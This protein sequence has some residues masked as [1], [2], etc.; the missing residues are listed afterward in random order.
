MARYAPGRRYD[1]QGIRT[2]FP[3][4]RRPDTRE[5]AATLARTVNET[6]DSLTPA[7]LFEAAFHSASIGMALVGLDG[8]WLRVN[9]AV[10]R[11]LG[12][13]EAELQKR[14]LQDITHPDDL[15]PGTPLCKQLLSGSIPQFESERRCLHKDDRIVWLL[16]SVALARDHRGQPAVFVVQMQDITARKQAETAR[17]MMLRLPVALHYVAG[18]DGYFKELS[19]SWADFLGYPI[20]HLLATPF[21]RLVH[22]DDRERT[23]EEIGRV[24]E[25]KN[26]FL[27]E[28]RYLH[29]DGST[30]WLLWT[31]IT[32]PE[33]KLIYGIALDYTAR[34]EAELALHDSLQEKE[35]LLTELRDAQ[36]ESQS[37]RDRLLT[38]CA[39]TKQIQHEGRWVP[40][41]EFLTDH[42]HLHLTHGISEEA[43]RDALSQGA[44]DDPRPAA[45][46]S[47]NAK[48]SAG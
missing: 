47:K 24:V 14:T 29:A 48:K 17:K 12:Y 8:K 34:K 45:P 19:P 39:W 40:V 35:R 28:N 10:C 46:L 26:T 27:F 9:Q 18:F 33:E 13:T 20:E 15:Q 1:R 32:S 22:P 5:L 37:L 31:S 23:L 2:R 7:R 25:G 44:W 4:R 41:D 38:I 11:L 43:M 6:T 30:R 42:L 21:M 16:L 3:L 36:R